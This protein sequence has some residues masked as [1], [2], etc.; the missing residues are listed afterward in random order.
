MQ[1]VKNSLNKYTVW[2]KLWNKK[3]TNNKIRNEMDK[4]HKYG[5]K[6]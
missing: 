4:L 2:K 1:Q 5:L 3:E 6:W